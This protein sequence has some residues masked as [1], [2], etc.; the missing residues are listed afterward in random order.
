MFVR[1]TLLLLLSVMTLTVRADIKAVDIY[2]Q[3]ELLQL[4][5]QGTELQRI[6]QDDCQLV[7]DIE[8]HASVLKEPLYQYLWGQMLNYGVCVKAEP[9]RG[10]DWLRQAAEQGSPEA[11][12]KLAQYYDE[13]K[14]LIKDSDRAVSYL[15]S[16]ASG[17][18]FP[19][20]MMLVK[21]LGEGHGTP[22][23]YV[24]AYHWLYNQTFADEKTQQQSEKLLA[25]LAKLMP[26]SQVKRAQQPQLHE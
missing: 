26:D 21:L 13:G 1:I 14:F 15:F 22:R 23:D 16:A 5:R 18:N 4:I 2:S 9:K 24:L 12:F 8:A 10:M 6:K 7:K 11:M 17:G 25:K 3:E 19:A 20:Q